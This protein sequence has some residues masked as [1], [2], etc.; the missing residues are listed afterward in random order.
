MVGALLITIRHTL[1]WFGL[2]VLGGLSLALE[3]D[4][5]S[6]RVTR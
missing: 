2:A 6:E 5:V 1:C 3:D 4:L